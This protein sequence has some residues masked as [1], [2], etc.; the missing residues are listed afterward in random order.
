LLHPEVPGQT[1]HHLDPNTAEFTIEN[2]GIFTWSKWGLKPTKMRLQ[3][4]TIQ[5]FGFDEQQS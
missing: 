1:F 4:F 3:K 2:E 5:K